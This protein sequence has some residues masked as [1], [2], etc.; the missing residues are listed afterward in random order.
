M[1]LRGRRSRPAT[2]TLSGKNV[3]FHCRTQYSQLL[4][5]HKI[6]QNMFP[7]NP[8]SDSKTTPKWVKYSVYTWRRFSTVSTMGILTVSQYS[9]AT[10]KLKSEACIP[11]GKC[12]IV[13]E[14]AGLSPYRGPVNAYRPGGGPPATTY[15]G[16]NEQTTC[17]KGL[18]S[19]II[20]CVFGCVT[21]KGW[22]SLWHYC[23]QSML[24]LCLHV[25][26]LCTSRWKV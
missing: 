20:L 11:I 10:M 13:Q 3:H 26:L 12:C 16:Q 22:P 15:N 7:R 25:R 5:L 14:S 8:D 1:G 9:S 24:K 23:R 19:P 21:I 6:G 17:R 4:W 18:P 2:G